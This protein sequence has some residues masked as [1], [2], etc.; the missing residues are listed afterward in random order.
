MS[1]TNPTPYQQAELRVACA[2]CGAHAGEWCRTGG[3]AAPAMHSRRYWAVWE[4]AE[5]IITD[6]EMRRAAPPEDQEGQR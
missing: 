1:R 4:I 6:Y 2:Y 3:H 5:P